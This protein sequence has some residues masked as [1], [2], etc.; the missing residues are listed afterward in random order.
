[1]NSKKEI[2]SVTVKFPTALSIITN[3]IYSCARI[4]YS[5]NQDALIRFLNHYSRQNKCGETEKAILEDI[6]RIKEQVK[7]IFKSYHARKRLNKG[8]KLTLSNDGLKVT[9]SSSVKKEK[10]EKRYAE[11]YKRYLL[12]KSPLPSKSVLKKQANI[13]RKLAKKASKNG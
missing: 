6:D 7:F 5:V 3:N 9:K 13:A 10:P 11:S 12:D 4:D 2:I 1:M 8:L